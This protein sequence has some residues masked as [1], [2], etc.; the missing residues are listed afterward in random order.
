MAKNKP[1]FYVVWRGNKPGVY[2]SWAECKASVNGFR[3]ARFKSFP[4]RAE[5]E[6]AFENSVQDGVEYYDH[7]PEKKATPP[8]EFYNKPNHGIVVD[9]ACKANPGPAEYR[10]VRLNDGVVIFSVPPFMGT[11]NV[12]EFLAIVHAMALLINEGKNNEVIYSDSLN[13]INWINA[14]KCRTKLPHE[15]PYQKAYSLIERAEA[16]LAKHPMNIRPKLKK[17]ETHL[18]GEN[19]ADYGRK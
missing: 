4:T 7:K 2:N 10:G 19:P 3:G 14:G 15:E 5:A 13:A 1:K 9:G 18:W 16:W 6:E 17:W 11:N 8:T 12:A